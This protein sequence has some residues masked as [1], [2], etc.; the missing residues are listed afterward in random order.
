LAVP[1]VKAATEAWLQQL[2][3]LAALSGADTSLVEEV[4]QW[5]KHGVKAVFLNGP[6]PPV[7]Y[8]NTYTFKQHESVCLER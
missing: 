4:R 1:A 3:K 2:D 8:D 6:P 5:V 7:V